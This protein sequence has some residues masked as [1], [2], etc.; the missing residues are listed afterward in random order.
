[1]DQKSNNHD[2]LLLYMIYQMDESSLSEL[3]EKYRVYNH[4]QLKHHLSREELDGNVEDCL[5]ELNSIL[6]K[7]IYAYRQDQ[8]ARFSTFYYC[9]LEHY[10]A[11]YR[12]QFWSYQKRTQKQTLSLDAY[13]GEDKQK[14]LDEYVANQDITL[15]GIY[16]LYREER[17]HILRQLFQE[18]TLSERKVVLLKLEGHTYEAIAKRVHMDVR[19]IEYILTKARKSKALID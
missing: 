2:D 9:F 3:L 10:I 4:I 8:N 5:A 11:N 6:I 14:R 1:M 16:T 19:Q 7:A 13:V 12:R 15:E 17:N 18:L